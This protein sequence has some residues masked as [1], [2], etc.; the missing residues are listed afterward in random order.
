MT[1]AMLQTVKRVSDCQRC[2]DIVF[3]IWQLNADECGV[4]THTVRSMRRLQTGS[5]KGMGDQV[6]ARGTI[7]RGQLLYH[8]DVRGLETPAWRDVA[9][10]SLA[11]FYET[12]KEACEWKH[13]Q[14]S[15]GW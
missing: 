3:K 8:I 4:L 10:G 11:A 9:L 6:Y 2:Q 7:A 14:G 1:D 5:L 12:P 13:A 15:F